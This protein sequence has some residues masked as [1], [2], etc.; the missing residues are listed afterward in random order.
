MTTSSELITARVIDTL[1]GR[2]ISFRPRASTV[3]YTIAEAEAAALALAEA[4]ERARD[5][6]PLESAQERY[7][8]ALQKMQR[9]PRGQQVLKELGLW[10]G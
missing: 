9:D 4:V 1:A 5:S 2:R 8:R 6:T 10:T 3:T 7:A